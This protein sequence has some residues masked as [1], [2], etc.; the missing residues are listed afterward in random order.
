MPLVAIFIASGAAFSAGLG[1]AI[2]L[3]FRP[4]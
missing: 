2:A 1:L 4:Y 3:L